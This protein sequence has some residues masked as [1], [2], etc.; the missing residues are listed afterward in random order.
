MAITRFPSELRYTKM[1]NRLSFVPSQ[2]VMTKRL[3]SVTTGKHLFS[4]YRISPVTLG[5]SD[6]RATQKMAG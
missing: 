3:L 5:Q 1:D 6:Q 4:E 2:I